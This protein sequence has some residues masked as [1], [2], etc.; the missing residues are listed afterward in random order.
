MLCVQCGKEGAK[1]INMSG[2]H[3]CDEN[4]CGS[5][6]EYIAAPEYFRH[7]SAEELESNYR[8]DYY[9]NQCFHEKPFNKFHKEYYKDPGY[10]WKVIWPDNKAGPGFLSLNSLYK[11][12]SDLQGYT[13]YW[14]L[15]SPSHHLFHALGEK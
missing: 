10:N 1:D 9:T 8:K 12:V 14:P 13:P 2:W 6:K 3:F 7:P 4:C 11:G 15:Y 5:F